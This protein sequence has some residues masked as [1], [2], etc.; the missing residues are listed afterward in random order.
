MTSFGSGY[1]SSTGGSGAPGGNQPDGGGAFASPTTSNSGAADVD[2]FAGDHY[3]DSFGDAD[4]FSAAAAA[5]G[6][7]GLAGAGMAHTA[8]NGDAD[9]AED[10]M[11]E[12]SRALSD[13]ADRY[14]E[15]GQRTEELRL[16]AVSPD[17]AVQVVVKADGSLVDLQFGDR[18]RTIPLEH[19]AVVVMETVRQAQA[20]IADEVSDVMSRTLG[21]EDQQ[22]RDMVLGNLR[23]RFAATDDLNDFHDARATNTT[24]Q[25]DDDD[26]N[27]P[28]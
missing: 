6:G 11:A 26:R 1:G 20:T 16:S 2:M 27:D 5:M 12:W 24:A 3:A 10:R 15:A 21:D 14:R 17:G 4:N 28:W 7:G 8:F 18:A 23:S 13:K 19:L 22:T 9:G 25:A